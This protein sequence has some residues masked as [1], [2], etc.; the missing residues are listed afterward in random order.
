MA[1]EKI[2]ENIHRLNDNIRSF[3]EI[4]AEYYK[5]D[6]FKISMKAA[7]SLVKGLVM[8]FVLL[9]FLFFIS[10]A[11]AVLISDA[12]DSPSSGFFIVGGFYLVLF[13]IILIILRPMI[14]KFLLVKFSRLYFNDSDDN[15]KNGMEKKPGNETV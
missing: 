9:F 15:N 4:S 12:L 11:V 8:G 6:V 1:F 7:T 13:I 3:A 10:L 14:D 5:L 2:K